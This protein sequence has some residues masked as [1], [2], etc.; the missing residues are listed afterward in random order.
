MPWIKEKRHLK[1]IRT[2]WNP[3]TN[4]FQIIKIVIVLDEGVLKIRNEMTSLMSFFFVALQEW[5][6]VLQIIINPSTW[7]YVD[8]IRCF[9]E[10]LSHPIWHEKPVC[11]DSMLW[12]E[13][14]QLVMATLLT[15][16]IIE[17]A[18]ITLERKPRNNY[19][20]S[21]SHIHCSCIK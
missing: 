15:W 13:F 6:G 18:N 5:S 11:I 19:L 7:Q 16:L 14:D 3:I 8:Y 4:Y 1:R 21:E 2:Q 10:L 20:N 17:K 12:T 9:T